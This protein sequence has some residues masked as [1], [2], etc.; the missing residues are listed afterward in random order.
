MNCKEANSKTLEEVLAFLGHLPTKKTEK[1]AWYLNPF[2]NENQASF[3]LDISRN[4]WYLFSEGIG[5]NNIDFIRKYFKCSISE[6]LSWASEQNFSSFHHQTDFKVP[7]Y[8]ITEISEI[9]NW[10]LKKYL[11]SRGLSQKIYPFIKEIKFTMNGKKLYAIGFQNQSGGWELRNSFYKGSIMKKDISIIKST[12][13]EKTFVFEGFFDALSFIELHNNIPGNILVLNSISLINKPIEFLK[14]NKEVY[15][16]LDND[17]AGLRCK[18]ILISN[19]QF[20]KDYSNIYSDY[21]DFNEYLINRKPHM[22]NL[23][24]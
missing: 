22:F 3:K 19:I 24:I 14:T 13:N 11:W 18:D 4:Q 6:A 2:A 16:F 15:L 5:G 10:N 20:A 7:K 1:E 9:K 12:N 21:K 8:E 23:E 17:G